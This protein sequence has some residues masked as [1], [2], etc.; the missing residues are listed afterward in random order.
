MEQKRI[1]SLHFTFTL[2]WGVIFILLPASNSSCIKYADDDELTPPSDTIPSTTDT[3]TVIVDSLFQA[4]VSYIMGE[5]M[6]QYSGFDPMQMKTSS[7]RRLVAFLPDGSYDSHVQGIVDIE[8]TVTV[9]KEFEHEHG[10][11]SFDASRQLMKYTVEYDSLLNFGSDQLE[12]SPG[13][14]RPGIGIIKEY[15]ERL[16]FSQEKEGK[17]DWVRKDDNLVSAD[18]HTE[19]IIYVMKSQQ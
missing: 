7:I 9:Y 3:T 1:K 2:L 17:R 18:D 16:W 8:D 14:M 15:D 12:Y 13:K 4:D 10:T 11:Y 5:W 19:N 6:A